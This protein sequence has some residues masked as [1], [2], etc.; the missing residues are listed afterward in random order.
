MTNIAVVIAV[1]DYIHETP[2]PACWRDGEAMSQLIRATGRFDDVLLLNDPAETGGAIA[3]ERLSEFADR[4]RNTSVDE[5]LFYF[6]GHGS[7]S[8]DELFMLLR[9]Y[10]DREKKQTSL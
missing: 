1:S 10:T 8:D 3:K 7:F 4:Y 5:V 6:S 9:D 2:L